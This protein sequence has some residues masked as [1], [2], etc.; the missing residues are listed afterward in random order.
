MDRAQAELR[1][2]VIDN[3]LYGRDGRLRDD[4]SFLDM[5]IIDSTG[6]LELV[7]FLEKQYGISVEEADLI[8]ENLDSIA[9][10]AGFLQRKL[11]QRQAP[12]VPQQLEQQIV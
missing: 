3:F 2:F 9:Q 8:P 4:D 7:N 12:M 11:D 1:R 5:G 10:L 6:L